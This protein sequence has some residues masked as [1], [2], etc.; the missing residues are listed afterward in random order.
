MLMND[1]MDSPLTLW[2]AY[3]Q[4]ECPQTFEVKSFSMWRLNVQENE[5]RFRY[6]MISNLSGGSPTN[7]NIRRTHSRKNRRLAMRTGHVILIKFN[8][9]YRWPYKSGL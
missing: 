8:E 2:R 1:V 7:Q 4:Q 6:A 9:N 3:K 5:W